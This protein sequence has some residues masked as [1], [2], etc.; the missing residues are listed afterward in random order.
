MKL[1]AIS[2]LGADQRVFK[3]LTLD[4]EIIPLEWIDPQ[5]NEP[6]ENYAIR[7]SEK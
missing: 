6:L 2:G 3:Y 4:C 7:L 5:K 1:Y